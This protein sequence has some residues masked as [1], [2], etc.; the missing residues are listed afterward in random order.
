MTAID[1]SR[2]P[3]KLNAQQF[4]NNRISGGDLEEGNKKVK[5]VNTFK[6]EKLDKF[7]SG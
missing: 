1:R 6:I 4:V 7:G 5:R 3:S 2:A